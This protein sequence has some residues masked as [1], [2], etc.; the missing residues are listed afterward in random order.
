MCCQ[1]ALSKAGCEPD[2]DPSPLELQ[3]LPSLKFP[4]EKK[5]KPEFGLT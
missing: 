4:E 3:L 5:K 1:A 2:P